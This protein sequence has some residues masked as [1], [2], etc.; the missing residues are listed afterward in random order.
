MVSRYVSFRYSI[1]IADNLEVPLRRLGNWDNLCVAHV[2]LYPIRSLLAG[3][4]RPGLAD[5]LHYCLR[6]PTR[7]HR[8]WTTL[9][10][11]PRTCY[12]RG[13]DWFCVGRYRLST[14]VREAAAGCRVREFYAV[15][16]AEDCVSVVYIL[17]EYHT[18]THSICYSVAILISRSKPSAQESKRWYGSLIDFRGFLDLRY[19][20]LCIGTFFAILGLWMP[21]YYI[22]TYSFADLNVSRSNT[23]EETYANVA[24]PNNIIA[25]YILCIMNG[26]SIVGAVL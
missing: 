21:S 1:C 22:S 11:A 23:L 3:R 9:L 15:S 13:V 20:I 6:Y 14:H 17:Q 8:R 18:N 16:G 7:T 12:G 10:P 24:Y 26:T 5:G 2:V 25:G 19:T 4:P